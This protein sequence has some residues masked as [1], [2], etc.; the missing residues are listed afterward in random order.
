VVGCGPVGE[1]AAGRL[2]SMGADVYLYDTK[3]STAETVAKTLDSTKVHVISELT[4]ACKITNILEATP[5][6]C[7]IPDSL[8]TATT[9]VAAPG[10]PLGLSQE[11]CDMLR[12]RLIH[13]KL[14]LG[15]AAMAVSLL[16]KKENR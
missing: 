5:S 1:C 12:E 4:T 7:S 11:Q 2:L 14:E 3:A 13:D 9:N 6:A 16:N 15:V 8:L 10:V